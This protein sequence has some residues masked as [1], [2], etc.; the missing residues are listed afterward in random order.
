VKSKVLIIMPYLECGGVE[1][2]LL[3]L[4]GVLDSKRVEITLL[5]LE[6]RGTFI[7][8]VPSHIQIKTINIPEKE[9][10]VFMGKKKMLI[11]YLKNRKIWKIP[12]FILYN[13]NK[14][15]S[16]DRASNAK[17]FHQISASIP[18]LEE[19]YDLAIDYFGYA[20]FTTFYLAEKV[21]AKKKVT[22]LHSIFSRFQ[23]QAFEEWY[24]K[25]DVIFACS[26]MVKKDFESIFPTIQTVKVFYNIINPQLIRKKADFPGG[27]EDQFSGIRIL[28]VGRICHEKGIDIAAQAY[29]LLKNAGYNIRWYI[30]GNGSDIEKE[31]VIKKIN[32]SNRADFIFLGIK[33]NPY[34]YMK[35][36]DIYVQPSRFEGYCTTTNEARIL[37]CPIVMT[38]VSGA[39]EQLENGKTGLIVEKESSAIYDAVKQFIEYPDFRKKVKENL[40][41]IESDTR[42]EV[43]KIYELL[44][45]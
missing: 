1:S 45:G 37:G 30:M 23:P 12:K 7:E 29:N 22:W 33:E 34:V 39:E 10:G 9:Q 38:D 15:L 25:M 31:N 13:Y 19:E 4:L 2:T 41:N 8:K 11:S 43:R 24:K 27:F 32:P 44:E 5:L 28:T 17:Y 42:Q 18:P 40:K 26:Q 14:T 3:S 20:T 6:E 16:E 21:K 35:Q 36:C